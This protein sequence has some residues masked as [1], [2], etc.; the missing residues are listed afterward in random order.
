[1]RVSLP[2]QRA[3]AA[4]A[5][6][7]LASAASAALG[8]QA[9]FS[10]DA[11]REPGARSWAIERGVL[12]PYIA[13]RTRDGHPNLEGRWAGTPGGD[14]LEEHPYVDISSP[15]EES[16][17]ADP[18]DGRIPYQPWALARR[19]EHRAG[20]ARGWPGETGVR[21]YTDP[22]THCFYSVP[23]ATYRGGFEIRQ[24][25]GHVLIAYTFGHYYRMIRTD[26]GGRPPDGTMRS[27]MG[28]SRGRWA[29]DTLI[30]EVT[31]LNARNWL[32]QVGNFFSETARVTERFRLAAA[33][34]IDYEAT[35]DDPRV[36]TR[37]WT[38]RLPIRRAAP[39]PRDPYGEELWEHACYEGNKATDDVRGLGFQWYRGVE[40]PAR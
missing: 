21:L 36:F 31:N 4:L 32:D 34:I 23:R 14:D 8:G 28:S 29:G 5:I 3:G 16:F 7:F 2:P 38:I 20:L 37:P 10:R 33:D 18:P 19:A 22:Q 24:G 6:A 35:I 13:P 30:V 15:P 26:G 40:P 17:V 39:D 1:M 25:P 12:P 11:P 9:L 27:W